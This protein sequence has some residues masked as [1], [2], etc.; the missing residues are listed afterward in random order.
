MLG[1]GGLVVDMGI[2]YKAK[3]EMRKAANAAALS[4]AQVVL[5]DKEY[6]EKEADVQEVAGDILKANNEYYAGTELSSSPD[7]VL[8]DDENKVTVTLKKKVSLYFMKIFGVVD[9][10]PI[11]V[12]SSAKAGK[13][14]AAGGAVPIGLPDDAS[15]EIGKSYPL[16]FNP[17]NGEKGNFEYLDFSNVFR[18]NGTK[19]VDPGGSSSSG[20]GTLGYYLLNGFG[21]DIGVNY[22]VLTETGINYG[23]VREAIESRINSTNPDDRIL[24]VLLYSTDTNDVSETLTGK[25]NLKITGFACFYLEGIQGKEITGEFIKKVE[26]GSVDDGAL[27]K[28]AYAI[29]LVE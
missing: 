2:A 17:G 21:Q 27:D 24:L 16:N 26:V 4:G 11:Q 3:S 5:S 10:V 7:I 13:L 15:F 19:V 18:P 6:T 9:P 12:S 1:V 22:H 29:K 20:A 23:K 25:T 28:G 14:G 8:S